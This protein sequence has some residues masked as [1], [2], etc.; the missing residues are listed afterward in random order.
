MRGNYIAFILKIKQ[1]I[2]DQILFGLFLGKQGQ[3]NIK[4][5]ST[6]DMICTS[7][8]IIFY[9]S[10]FFCLF[11]CSYARGRHSTGWSYVNSVNG[12]RGMRC[13]YMAELCDLLLPSYH[14]LLIWLYN[15]ASSCVM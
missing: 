5:H 2:A 9:S 6:A 10:L 13:I 15:K 8:F 7:P 1:V 11:I 12:N 4:R 3:T 14:S